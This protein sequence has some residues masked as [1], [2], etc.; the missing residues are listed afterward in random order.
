MPEPFSASL[1][2]V[3]TGES[4]AFAA[5]IERFPSSEAIED[6]QWR[7][8]RGGLV[9]QPRDGGEQPTV[10][11]VSGYFPGATDFGEPWA[12]EGIWR[13]PEDLLHQLRTWMRAGTELRFLVTGTD[14]D[15][16]VFLSAVEK[17][18]GELDH[19]NFTLALVELR[20]I[21]VEVI[22]QSDAQQG[23][24]A[25]GSARRSRGDLAFR[26]RRA[27]EPPAPIPDVFITKYAMTLAGVAALCYGDSARWVE[28]AA[29][30]AELLDSLG[31]PADLPA[32]T[33][34]KVPGG[35]HTETAA[36][37]QRGIPVAV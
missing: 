23:T 19:L 33:R 10:H 17:E 12:L 3:R 4:L 13:P 9:R 8:L 20:S 22:S 35:E 16:N 21:W 25:S 1:V 37:R 36:P 30:N 26:L 6:Q 31:N 27:G 28:I 15:V 7:L 5:T 24:A 14:I 18:F 2:D 29:A 11:T 32:G 34:L